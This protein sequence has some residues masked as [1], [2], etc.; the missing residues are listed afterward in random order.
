M[1]DHFRQIYSGRAD[2]YHRMIAVEDADGVLARFLDERLPDGERLLDLGGGTGRF[3]LQLAG[4]SRQFLS[5]DL[6]EAMLRE[7]Q[8]VRDAAGGSWGLVQGDMRRL[9]LP[10]GWADASLAG[11]SLG[12]FTGWYPDRWQQEMAPVL[13]EMGRVTKRDGLL[14]ICETMT[15]GGTRPAPPSPVL[16][17]YY[18]WLEQAHGFTRHVI[19]TDYQF[20]S[21]EAAVEATEFFFG[22]ELSARIRIHGWDRLPEW[23]GIWTKTNS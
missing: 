18:D 2:A 6:H 15:T 3:G 8:R 14:L 16:A 4:R 23:T 13:D 11:W 9:P 22:P 20:P 17:A 19:P 10:A 21:V 5:L 12:H 1:S 7:Q